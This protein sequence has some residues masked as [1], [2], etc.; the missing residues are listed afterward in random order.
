V[1]VT[2]IEAR[3]ST[4]PRSVEKVPSVAELPTCEKTL[5]DRA[6]LTRFTLLPEAVMSVDAALKTNTAFGSPCASSVTV[7]VIPKVPAGES[8]TPGVL[9]VPPSSTGTVAVVA[10]PAALSYAVTRSL[11]ACAAAASAMCS[12]PFTVPGGNP[13]TDVP[14]LSPRSPLTVVA[15]VFVTVEA[16]RIA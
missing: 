8:Y 12:V 7:P 6:P 9:V 14:G 10:R 2:V 15:P 16:A 1:A 4:F 11:L 5:H 3:A 13:V